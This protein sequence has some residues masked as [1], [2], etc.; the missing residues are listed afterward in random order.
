MQIIPKINQQGFNKFMKNSSVTFSE[1][2]ITD[3]QTNKSRQI[4][5]F[6]LVQYYANVTSLIRYDNGN[7]VSHRSCRGFL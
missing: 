7:R 5:T 6:L 4:H 1:I 3:G 2:L